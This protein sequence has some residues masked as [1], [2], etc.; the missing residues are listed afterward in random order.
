[1]NIVVTCSHYDSKANEIV[2]YKNNVDID[3]SLVMDFQK[4][5]DVLRDLYPRATFITFSVPTK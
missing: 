3:S 5:Y 2:D 1:M 4:F